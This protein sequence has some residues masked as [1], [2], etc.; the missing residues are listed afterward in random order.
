MALIEKL[1]GLELSDLD[2]KYAA[3]IARSKTGAGLKEKVL[4]NFSFSELL[5]EINEIHS[6]ILPGSRYSE[7]DL[8]KYEQKNYLKGWSIFNEIKSPVDIDAF[9]ASLIPESASHDNFWPI[10]SRQLLGS[11]ITYS[12]H[13][14]QTSYEELWKLVNLGNEE[15][16]PLFQSTPGCEEGVKLLTEAKT[17]NNILAVLSNY[18]KP[19]KYLKGTDGAF[20]IKGWV[21]DPNPDKRII[22]LSNVA[23]IQET[24][25]P[26]LTMFVDFST[27]TL[28]S[29]DD[30]LNRRL[31]FILDEFGQLSKIGSIISLLTQSRSKGGAAFIL[32]QDIA[33]ISSTYGKDGC[34]SIVNSCGNTI[35]FAVSD[36]STADFI[37]KK[38][39]TMEVKRSEENKSMGVDS[40]NSSISI[41][42]QTT[43][44]RLVMPSEVMSVP[45]MNFYV[46]LTDYPVTKDKLDYIKFPKIT[47]SYL[48]RGD[49]MFA[50]PQKDSMTG[51]GA[52]SSS[53]TSTLDEDP[54]FAQTKPISESKAETIHEE[55]RIPI[56]PE[57]LETP[58]YKP[59][60][61]GDQNVTAEDRSKDKDDG[62]LI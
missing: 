39:G 38:I 40:N 2:R 14:G 35:S 25:K 13:K 8:K 34:T 16:L 59:E 30:D 28:C 46:Q 3:K 52:T 27:K 37:S 24:I 58:E 45:T 44:K 31:Y 9:C 7:I 22:F 49:L 29:L 43:E 57:A 20:S 56:A 17:A 48:E 15:L 60:F 5:D 47:E 11:I 12:L 51:T 61:L 21:K 62:M 6:S 50:Q 10:S 33:Q 41:S 53:T 55:E 19:I 1:A 36:E 42:H 18:T 4:E 23:M 32:I 54:E 26:F